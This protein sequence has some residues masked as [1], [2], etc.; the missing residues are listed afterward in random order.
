MQRDE[1]RALAKEFR[2]NATHA[3]REAWQVL[4]ARRC[5]GR[6]FKRQFPLRGFIVDFFCRELTLILEVDGTVHTDPDQRDHDAARDELL[7]ACGF[8]VLRVLNE[9][10]TRENLE[11]LLRSLRDVPPPLA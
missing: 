11:A 8:R 6:K 7:S 9:E 4:R 1:L 10:V 5:L 3:E 2:K